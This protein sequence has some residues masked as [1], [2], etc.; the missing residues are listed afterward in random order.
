MLYLLETNLPENKSVFFALTYIYGIG[1]VNGLKFGNSE[2]G[3]G[4][5]IERWKEPVFT[6]YISY[7]HTFDFTYMPWLCVRFDGGMAFG[8]MNPDEPYPENQSN[9][10]WFLSFSP[11]ARV[12]ISDS[13]LLFFGNPASQQHRG[14]IADTG[15]LEPNFEGHSTQIHKSLR[16][17][18]V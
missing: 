16:L 6:S 14:K 17:K 15:L 5:G 1:I 3:I 13:G 8:N 12:K 9:K 7:L 4:V 10:S 11:L 2:L 18:G